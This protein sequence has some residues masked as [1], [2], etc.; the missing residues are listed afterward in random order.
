MIVAVQINCPDRAVA[1]AIAEHLVEARLAAAVH[2]HAPLVSLYRW[3]G[4]V[5]EATEVPLV[6]RTR[7]DLFEPLAAAVRRL[8]PFRTP[9][10]VAHPVAAVPDDYRDWVHA[11]TAPAPGDPSPDG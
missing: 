3:Q 2:I 10:I 9:S 7:A 1:R 11:Q 6:A 8:H 4:A 5:R